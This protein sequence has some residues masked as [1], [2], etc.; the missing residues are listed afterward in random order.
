MATRK[1][2]ETDVLVVDDDSTTRFV[3][4]LLLQEKLYNVVGE[5]GDGETAVALCTKLKPHIVFMDIDMPKLNGTQAAKMIRETDQ[6]VGIIMVSAVST[7]VRA[8]SAPSEPSSSNTSVKM[9]SAMASSGRSTGMKRPLPKS[10]GI[11]ARRICVGTVT[12]SSSCTES[13][14]V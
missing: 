7:S 5:A 10:C 6:Q 4:R 14:S 8:D 2:E 1:N 11:C 3:L 9:F 12:C 13:P